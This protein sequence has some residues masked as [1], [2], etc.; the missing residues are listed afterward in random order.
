VNS[1]KA[2]SHMRVIMLSIAP[3]CVCLCLTIVACSLPKQPLLCT[4]N[5]P[6]RTDRKLRHA[7]HL[8]RWAQRRTNS[9]GLAGN[10]RT[11][12]ANSHFVINIAAPERVLALSIG[13]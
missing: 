6:W 12:I 11:A 8:Q 10:R 13:P 3:A 2:N 7:D 1:E 4:G 9:G 5:L